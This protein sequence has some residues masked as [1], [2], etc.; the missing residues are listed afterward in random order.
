MT[1]YA[2]LT[3]NIPTPFMDLPQLIASFK[4]QGLDIKDLVALSGAHTIAVAQ[5]STYRDR[6]YNDTNIDPI[7]A[8]SL[9]F[10]CPP[11]PSGY[12]SQFNAS[13]DGTLAT[14]DSVYYFNLLHQK[15]LLHSDQAL[16]GSGDATDA[17]VKVYSVNT[18]AFWISFANSMIKMGNIKPLIGLEG[19]IRSNCR[20]AN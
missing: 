16:F 13:M 1:A 18:H 20:K 5:C 17:L 12:E 4:N 9:K 15:G 19:E 8:Q 10:I 7:F 2:T 6:L 3:T 14:F 11:K